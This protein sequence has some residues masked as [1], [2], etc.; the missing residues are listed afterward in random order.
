MARFLT[1]KKQR[2]ALFIF[3][4]GMCSICGRPLEKSWHADHITPYCVS[5][6]TDFY[7]MQATCPKCNQRKG[8]KMPLELR[9]WQSECLAHYKQQ[10]GKPNFLIEACPGAGKTVTAIEIAKLK[11]ALGKKIIVVVPTTMLKTQWQ[12]KFHEN[13]IEL[14]SNFDGQILADDYD[15][16]AVT[17]AQVCHSAEVFRMNNRYDVFP[18]FDEIH[19]C[20]EN[21]SWGEALK[22]AFELA[23]DRLSLSGTPFRSDGFPIP[24]VSYDEVGNSMPDFQY[25]YGDAVA[26]K[27][28]RRIFFKP[29]DGSAKWAAG[30][31]EHIENISVNNSATNSRKLRTVL[32][33]GE[34]FEETFKLANEKLR[35]E[36][37]TYP[38]A[39]G[40]VL[41]IDIVEAKRR[42]A[43]IKQ[44][45]GVT[46]VIVCSEDAD[47]AD[48][49]KDFKES[50][51]DWIVSVK[52][53]SEGVD[54][55]RLSTGVFAT[56]CTS[57][58]FFRQVAGRF[59]RVTGD[60]D[61]G[62]YLYIPDTPALRSNALEI[63]EEVDNALGEE[64]ES[65]ESGE[66]DKDRSSPL[67]IPLGSKKTQE[68]NIA[69]GEVI[70]QWAMDEARRKPIRGYS[71]EAVALVI[72]KTKDA[73][74]DIQAETKPARPTLSLEE[75]KK[76][77]RDEM[78]PLVNSIAKTTGLEHHEVQS[79]L[80]NSVGSYAIKNMSME[81]LLRRKENAMEWA[82]ESA[83]A[84]ASQ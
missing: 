36:Q 30:V 9:G 14:D 15:G 65:R 45:T 32:T 16:A 29:Q 47:A 63:E 84:G 46:P 17:Y 77:L 33:T 13:G 31:S 44:V 53:V 82:T 20:G 76:K 12:E 75:E 35:E 59:T 56:N 24:F 1:S 22:F 4:G 41:T 64:K 50:T 39:A 60:P 18:I 3:S 74:S 58:M 78:V 73:P 70:P 67:F 66:R 21:S 28:C 71:T 10:R 83:L 27:C 48:R 81:Q 72:F 8:A 42:A 37:K 38:N 49:I 19:H 25:A 40:L 80:N 23:D 79:R 43:V 2:N 26:D 5:K 52:M 62:G 51:D 61:Q 69:A 11:L 68:S 6:K 54:I 7:D 34:W 55:P 57:T